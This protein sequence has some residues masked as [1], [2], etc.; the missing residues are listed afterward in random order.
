M[1]FKRAKIIPVPKKN[2]IATLNDY[3][4]VALTAVSMKSFEKIVLK[5]IKSL[6]PP[7]FDPFQFAYRS[8]RSVEDAILLGVHKILQHLETP[9]VIY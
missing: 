8:N 9:S 7:D 4:P 1:I 5:F 2:V 3:R 6:L